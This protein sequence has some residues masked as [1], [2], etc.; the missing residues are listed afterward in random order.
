[1]QFAHQS[2]PGTSTNNPRPPGL[3][4][5]PRVAQHDSVQHTLARARLGSVR[6]DSRKRYYLCRGMASW[7]A[8]FSEAVVFQ[9]QMIGRDKATNSASRARS[10]TALLVAPTHSVYAGRGLLRLCLTPVFT[11]LW[12]DLRW[13]GSAAALLRHREARFLATGLARVA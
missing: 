1:M 3:L 11:G 10:A 2:R 4:E 6:S 8:S 7:L 12:R 5:L 13:C 9:I